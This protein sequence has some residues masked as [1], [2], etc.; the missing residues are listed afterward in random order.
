MATVSSAVT[1]TLLHYPSGTERFPISET[2]GAS[3]DD[4]SWPR[5]SDRGHPQAVEQDLHLVTTAALARARGDRHCQVRERQAGCRA[6]HRGHAGLL[7][8]AIGAI[9]PNPC[10]RS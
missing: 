8:A 6:P 7:V 3:R 2:T 5:S 4:H 10:R 1:E 9:P